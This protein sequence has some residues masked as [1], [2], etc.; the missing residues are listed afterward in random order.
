[1]TDNGHDALIDAYH[2]VLDLVQHIKQ[3]L[4][5]RENYPIFLVKIYLC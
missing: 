3:E 4:M 5:E 1:M 2:D